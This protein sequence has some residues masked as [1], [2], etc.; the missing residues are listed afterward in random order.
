[1]IQNK[2]KQYDNYPKNW[3]E[4]RAQRLAIAKNKCEFCG[5][6][7]G[8]EGARDNSGKFYDSETLFNFPLNKI[9]RLFSNEQELETVNIQPYLFTLEQIQNAVNLNA[10][11]LR[12]IWLQTAHL[13]RV[14]QNADIAN[15][16]CLCPRC[17]ILYD[18]PY[19]IQKRK[20]TKVKRTNSA[21]MF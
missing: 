5:I 8:V 10:L 1:M 6:T 14:P 16:R 15:L 7:N 18:S 21:A 19:S 4:L 20:E 13:D 2:S 3:A 12:R 11:P 9:L 17:H